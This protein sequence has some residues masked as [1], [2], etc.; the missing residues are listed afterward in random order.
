[1]ADWIPALDGV[2]ATLAAGDRVADIGCGHGASTVL[3]AEAFPAST[4]VGSDYHHGSI[5]EAPA[6]LGR[7][8]SPSFE[9]AGA[10]LVTS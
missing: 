6:P 4:Y 9:V 10:Q 1:M 5:A 7:G 3:M 2:E 8:A